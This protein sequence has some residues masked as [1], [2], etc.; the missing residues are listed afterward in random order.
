MPPPT[1][2]TAAV[3]VPKVR[4][5]VPVVGTLPAVRITVWP[6]IAVKVPPVVPLPVTVAVPAAVTATL[7]VQ[8]PAAFVFAH[9]L[10]LSITGVW[11][12]LAIGNAC[13]G[14]L[15]ALWFLRGGWKRKHVAPDGAF[16]QHCT[17]HLARALPGLATEVTCRRRRHRR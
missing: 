13:N 11:L 16:R 1:C 10:G 17:R 7:A 12:G 4:W 3:T 6:A 14:L 5:K 15:M 9:V 2:V 8:V